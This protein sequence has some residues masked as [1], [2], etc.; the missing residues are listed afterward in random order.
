MKENKKKR[1]RKDI[2]KRLL[3]AFLAFLMV[4]GAFVSSFYV[5]LAKPTDSQVVDTSDKEMLSKV[6]ELLIKLE[7][8][9]DDNFKLIQ[10]NARLAMLKSQDVAKKV[11]VLMYHHLYQGNLSESEFSGNGAV[12]SVSAFEEQMNYLKKNNFYTATLDELYDFIKKR[13]DLPE[14]TVVITFD[15]G[16]YSNIEYAYPIL[17][18]HNFKATIFSIGSNISSEPDKY[19]KETGKLKGLSFNDLKET[20]DVFDFESHTYDLHREISN[21]AALEVITKDNLLK[22]I[23]SMNKQ[24]GSKYISYPYGKYTELNI[25]AFEESGYKL[26]FTIEEGYTS[27][28][29]NLFKIPRFAVYP[30]T[31]MTTFKSIVNLEY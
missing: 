24:L 31:N 10:E 2:Q 18:K 7:N 3:V 21:D 16:Y 1:N 17:K 28:E 27:S 19:S 9:E 23:D 30:W 22:D 6:K 11:P 4:L 15:D 26:G 20:S 13:I 14:K 29:S 25:K 8:L 12:I 5:A